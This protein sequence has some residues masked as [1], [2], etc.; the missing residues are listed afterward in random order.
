MGG[1]LSW[2]LSLLFTPIVI[3][4][5]HRYKWIAFPKKD[6]W[7]K[8]PTALMGGIA[9]FASGSLTVLVFP[10]TG[11]PWTLCLGAAIMFVTGLVDDFK[12]IRPSRK[13]AAQVAASS[14][15]LVEG[16][17]FGEGFPYWILA[18]LTLFWAIGIT[19]ALNLLDNMDGLAAGIACI[20]S[21]MLGGFSALSGNATGLFLSFVIA[22]VSAGFLFY[23]FKP[24][25]IFM[26]D[27][28]SMF[29]GYSVAALAVVVQA[30]APRGHELAIVLVSIL[31]LAIPILDTT[32]VTIVRTL[33][34]ISISQGGRDHSSHRLVFLGLSEKNAVLTLYSVGTVSGGSALLFHVT[35]PI[36]FGALFVLLATG[37]IVFGIFLA[38]VNVY[39]SRE[40]LGF[41]STRTYFLNGKFVRGV[42]T[43]LGP[44]WKSSF[45]MI[46]DGMLVMASLILAHFLRYED[47]VAGP[48]REALLRILPIVVPVKVVVFYL[49]G[50]YR[51]IWQ[52][53]G[54]SE[55]VQVLQATALTSVIT[56]GAVA[57]AVYDA[58]VAV[59]IIDWIILSVGLVSV[60]FGLK[61]LRQFIHTQR[62]NGRRVV[63]YGAGDAGELALREIRQNPELSLLPIGFIDDNPLKHGMRIDGVPV[64]GSF[65]DFANIMFDH[66]PEAVLITAC[67]I[68]EARKT[69]I[70]VECTRFDVECLML[71]LKIDTMPTW[72]AFNSLV[73]VRTKEAH[74]E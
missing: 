51:G 60:R 27:S 28:G 11:V 69:E 35:E 58:S 66:Q 7:H 42:Q 34:G 61:A 64:L 21:L 10:Q 71:H 59:F 54:V 26:G 19:N 62:S 4:V 32:L 53:A 68:T 46:A 33:S 2:C 36:L 15:L 6:R 72:P 63:L 67:R 25:R 37:L 20:A 56:Y 52:H 14:L 31:V 17:T 12:T 41:Y 24:A 70:C 48:N 3:R 5:A 13:L 30:Q 29:L 74:Q 40:Q 65:T 73:E 39:T 16:Y 57:Y 8:K 50:L 38:S 1:L 45:G 43:L 55:M 18:P 49:M 47:L 23:N 22:G 44:N 9:L